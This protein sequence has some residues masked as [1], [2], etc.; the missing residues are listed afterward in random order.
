MWRVAFARL[1][2]PIRRLGGWAMTAEAAARLRSSPAWKRARL[3]ILRGA[4]HCASCH[5]ALDLTAPPR[6]SWAPTVDHIIA[7][8]D[9][10]AP[11]DPS[12]LRVLHNKCNIAKE[13]RRRAQRLVPRTQVIRADWREWVAPSRDWF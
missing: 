2:F 13:N 9:G 11:F 6:S 12:N 7:L 4:T 8:V 5:R 1:T 10:G 3:Q